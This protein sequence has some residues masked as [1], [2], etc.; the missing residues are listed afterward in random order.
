M[1]RDTNGL[2]LRRAKLVK[3][4]K[5][6]HD[7]ALYYFGLSKSTHMSVPL[8]RHVFIKLPGD[9]FS[10]RPYTVVDEASIF[11]L[12]RNSKAVV[13][14]DNEQQQQQQLCLIIKHYSDGYLT[15]KL[16]K[17]EIGNN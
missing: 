2:H 10:L 1:Q 3:R 16:E 6:T 7:T 4:V 8:G 14:N 12:G 13:V 15:S 5:M 17:L 9:S 11:R